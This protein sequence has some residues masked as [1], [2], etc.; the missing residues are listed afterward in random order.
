MTNE[1][2]HLA[3]CIMHLCSGVILAGGASRRMGRDKAWIEF[4]GQS[5]VERVIARLRLVCQD[6]V[7]V[8]SNRE[9]YQLLD[10]RIVGDAFPGKGSLGGIY[11][12]LSVTRF[13]RVIVVA[14]DMP[15]LN[16]ELLTFMLSLSADHDVVIPSAAGVRGSVSAPPDKPN[17][18]RGNRP[19]A[20]DNDLHPLHAVYSKR[21][22]GPIEARLASDDLRLISFHSEVRVRVVSS[23]EI[24]RF[25]PEHL[26]LFNVN[27]PEDLALAENF[28]AQERAARYD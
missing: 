16:T 7:L 28:A 9:P 24:D 6:I 12:G 20:K 5:L 26:S 18:G 21:C 14:C 19:T 8:T 27:T 13:D 17:L 4:E 25:D 23:V 11:S 1:R 10:A 2:A 22:L 3:L 15:F